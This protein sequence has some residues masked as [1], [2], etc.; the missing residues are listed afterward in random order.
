MKKPQLVLFLVLL[1]VVPSFSEEPGSVGGTVTDAKGVPIPGA[2]V[3]VFDCEGNKLIEALTELE[4]SFTFRE[5]PVGACRIDVEIVGFLKSAGNAIDTSTADGSC[6]EIHMESLPRPA[7]AEIQ[8]QDEMQAES[9]PDLPFFQDAEVTDLPGLSQY[10]PFPSES[11]NEGDSQVSSTDNLLLINGNSVTLDSGNLDDPDFLRNIMDSARM[12]GFG[13]EEFGPGSQSGPGSGGEGGGFTAM[14]GGPGGGGPGGG[15]PGFVRMGGRGGPGAM[16]QQSKIEGSLFETYSNSALNARSYSLTG[17]TLPKPVQIQNNFGITLGGVLPFFGT[18]SGS[19]RGFSGRGPGR[20]GMP[21]G[22]PGWSVTYSGS[23]NR[24]ALDILT[25][26]P[27]AL[28]R[29]GDFS[30]TFVQTLVEDPVTGQKA[31]AY[32]PVQLYTDPNDPSSAFTGIDEVG[33]IDPAA[34]GLLEFIPDANLPCEPGVP[35]VNNYAL[36]RSL[37]NVSDEVQARVTGLRIASKLNLSVDYSLSRRN[38]Q[39]AAVFPDLDSTQDTFSQRMGISST[40]MFPQRII[41]NWRINFDRSRNEST[42]SFANNR[43]VADEFGITGVSRDPINWGPPTINFTSYGNL[44]LSAP[45]FDRNQ[46]F[47]ISG[48]LN[49][50]GIRHSLR[51]GADI[52]WSQ[53]NTQSDS[54]GRGAFTFTGYATVLYDSEG[55]QVMGTGYDFAD[56]LLGLPYSTSRR[57]VDTSVNPMGNSLYLRSRS[58]NLY[59]MD[60]WQIRSNLTLNYGIRYEYAGPTYEKYDR[61]VSLD[62]SP[63]LQEVDRVFP[64]QEGPL[65]GQYFSRSVVNP[66]RNNFAP[67]IGIAWRPSN[68]LPIVVRA[69]YGVGYDTSGYASIARQMVNQAPFALNQNLATSSSN[70]LTL[71][72]GF[73]VDP[74]TDILNTYAIDP[75]Y[76]AAYAQQWNL[77]IQTQLFRI[78]SLNITY[79]GAKGTG[80]DIMR[81]PVRTESG[82]SYL[83]QTNGGNSI[84]HGLDIQVSRRFSRGVNL[85]GSYTFSKSIDNASG[86]G[87]ASIAQ[88]DA[89]L[90][91]ERSLS[92][93]DRRHNFQTNFVYEFPFG[94]NRMFFSSASDTVLNFVSGWTVNGNLSLSSG[95]PLTARYASSSGSSSGAALYS[96]LRPDSTGLPVN[97]SREERAIDRYFNT[98]AFTIPAG[99]YGNVGR[100]TIIGP[101]TYLVNLSIRKGFNLDDNFRRLDLSWQIQNL[102]NHANWSRVETTLNA[103]NFGQVTGVGAMRSMTFNLR[104]RF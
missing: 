19:Q 93:Q 92:S 5:L 69:G 27:T 25:T 28:E 32:Q 51:T 74:N 88:N 10:Q 47:S 91:A 64:N 24:N 22:Q 16:F 83:Y 70:L 23:R 52:N 97:L 59:V 80:L 79:S 26:V 48:S 54:N 8:K 30:Q 7:G 84:Y 67:R 20:G 77:D 45:A 1:V 12:M 31:I 4:G 89:D 37:I 14:Q 71:Q 81:A 56:F 18:Q 85:R 98:A 11:V 61:L 38:S 36:Q 87:G 35:C 58:W 86:S 76:R 53:R 50:I 73:P 34:A 39:N 55:N 13:L 72:N 33:A 96:S 102:L 103:L 40:T 43:N 42:N 21:G 2:D 75:D 78:Y 9:V 66:D 46:N 62:T 3:L 104:I 95:T 44:S 29:S 41:V 17:E 15:G 99:E 65:S 82:Y 68:R 49:K 100:N 63:D 6:L 90:G 57:Y 101:G 60:N 94:Q